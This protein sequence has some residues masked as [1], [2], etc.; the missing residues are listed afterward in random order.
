MKTEYF[1]DD[2]LCPGCDDCMQ[3][4][5]TIAELRHKDELLAKR[6]RGLAKLRPVISAAEKLRDARE[7][8]E[9]Y[10]QL[11]FEEWPD[12]R[13]MYSPDRMGLL[14]EQ[15]GLAGRNFDRAMDTYRNAGSHGD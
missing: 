10:A 13:S 8:I 7:A 12:G 5:I 3:A 14:R 4:P 15:N 11:Q 2:A 9:D 6:G 1:H